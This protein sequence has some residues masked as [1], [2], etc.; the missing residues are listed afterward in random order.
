[1]LVRHFF[2]TRFVLQTLN[3]QARGFVHKVNASRVSKY[4]SRAKL[5]DSIGLG[6]RCGSTDSLLPILNDPN[7][8]S[9]VVTNALKSAPSPESALSFAE[10]LKV[11]PHFSH[12]QHAL[13]AIA[14][15]LAKSSRI[16][17]LRKLI[18]AI[19]AREFRKVQSVSSMDCMRWY[20][21][22]GDLDLVLHVWDYLRKRGKRPCTEAYNIVMDVY[23]QRGKDLDAVQTF[24]RMIE[25]GAIPNSRTYTV[26][27]EHLVSSGKIDVAKEIFDVLPSMR[28][29]HTL[30]QYSLLMDA[31]SKMEQ[32]DVVKNLLYE[33][34]IEGALPRRSI[35]AS[36]QKMQDA[37][38]LRETSELIREM[39]PNDA[40][41]KVEFC[42]D[43]SDYEDE[44]DADDHS[45][46]VNVTGFQLKPWLD[47]SALASALQDW[48]PEDVSDLED[49]KF[50]GTSRLV[51]KMIRHFK[52]AEV[53]WQFVCWVAYQ[54]EFTHDVHTV[55]RMI[56]KSAC[57]GNFDLVDQLSLK[58]RKEGMKL[59]FSTIRLIVD[60]CGL[61]KNGDVALKVFSQVKELCGLI[62][63]F[64]SLLLYS[65]LLRTLTKCGRGSDAMVIVEEMLLSG[66]HPDIQTFSGLMHH[67]AS[68][69]DF[70]TVQRLFTMVRQCGVHPDAYM[71][72]ILIH[73]Y[74]KSE[75]AALAL[76]LFEDMRNSN[77]VPDRATKS[78]LVRSLWKVGKLREA[79]IVDESCVE[80]DNILPL[81]LPGHMFTVSAADLTRVY[82][83]Y[84]SSFT[85][86]ALKS[87]LIE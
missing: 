85:A 64:N 45:G 57:C 68:K 78:L 55:S 60:F 35:L 84:T 75:R 2:N 37:G 24:Y 62:S 51:C 43:D 13:H 6:L 17:E 58:M 11:V 20:A 69:G 48:R 22:A 19:N 87:V 18:D 21:A 53:A 30:K 50:V 16:N 1:M 7:L 4:H 42:T 71:Y 76:T 81:A 49:A 73:A 36:L 61:S 15:I 23:A 72:K 66:I 83:M 47:P 5:I 77:L 32:F 74:C 44:E 28:I 59:P 27:I 40:I 65:S 8:D 12:T 67:F 79:A 9:F 34:Q 10:S 54:P 56:A 41:K 52:S 63:E 80:M 14:K 46:D 82:N 26:I 29:K 25:E 3:H 70:R 39:L 33:M 31:F 86:V 38:Y